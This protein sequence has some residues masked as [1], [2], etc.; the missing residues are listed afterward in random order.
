[1]GEH[2]TIA[3]LDSWSKVPTFFIDDLFPIANGIPTSFWK[4]LLVVWRDIVDQRPEF[5]SR[6]AITD[7]HVSKDAA[8]KW[9]AALSVSC[10][11]FVK[12]GYRNKPNEPGVPTVI[13]YYPHSTKQDWMC[14]MVALRETVLADHR[15]H[16]RDVSGFRIQL[17]FNL[18]QERA[19][20][21][22]STKS[23][24]DYIH[25]LAA[26][27]AITRNPDG[28]YTW[29]RQGTNRERLLTTADRDALERQFGD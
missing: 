26:K 4:Y 11:F 25:M 29:K 28:E 5:T 7:F 12:Y 19:N 13:E 6:K 20:A 21:G 16:Y 15:N 10:L 18:K 22:L 9:T 2:N 17:V 3:I 14:F 24:E 1:M 23:L 27:G 8:S